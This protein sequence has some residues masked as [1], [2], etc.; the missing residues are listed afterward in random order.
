MAAKQIKIFVDAHSFDT[1]FQGAQTFIRELYTQLMA[2]HPELDIYFGAC[3]L[4]NIQ[5]VF[6][7]L[8]AANI[9]PYKKRKIGLLRFVL[10][11]PA[12][13]KKHR[14]DFAHFQY[15][16]PKKT[17]GCKYIVTLHDVLFND[18]PQDFSFIY[19]VSRSLLFGRSIKKA[20][21]KTT[22][23]PYSK[24]RICSYYNI[25]DNQVHII[26]NGVSNTLMQ[27]QNNRQKAEELV[28][29]KF[30]VDNFILYTSR[31]E[32]RKNHLLLLQKYL[33][34]KLYE[35]GIALVFIG[36]KSVNVPALIQLINSLTK[37]QKSHFHWF[38]QV[39]QAD[40]A[41]FYR[42]CRVF[43]YPTKAE[44]F[45]IPPLEAAICHAP[46]LCSS[47]TAMGDFKFFE[48]YTFD[49]ANDEELGQKLSAILNKPPSD[50]FISGIAKQITQQY[51]WQSS[52]NTFYHLLQ[53]NTI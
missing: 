22:V 34:L 48:P 40:L 53:A 52:S 26:Q 41:A 21:I 17:A 47:T 45:G 28:K 19:R 25:P 31:V 11:I 18:Y 42:A 39:A 51:N 33:K 23:S 4:E 10:D 38:Q 7:D 43:V 15:I 9:L 44:G 24:N 36:R 16:I 13:L 12:L 37:E 3:D 30:G 35:Q 20:H 46:V 32:P 8:P 49:P 50:S 27:F 1:E 5:S 2:D 14:F 29:Q 6:P